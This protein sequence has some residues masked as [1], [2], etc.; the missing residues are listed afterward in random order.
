MCILG[1]GSCGQMTSVLGF[2]EK[3]LQVIKFLVFGVLGWIMWFWEAF[4]M[5]G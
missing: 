4:K 5:V 3:P 2:V 1:N